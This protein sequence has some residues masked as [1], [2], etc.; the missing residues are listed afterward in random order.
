[1]LELCQP[2]CLIREM[3]PSDLLEESLVSRCKSLEELGPADVRQAGNPGNARLSK[4]SRDPKPFPNGVGS[5][6]GHACPFEDRR[7]TQVQTCVSVRDLAIE[8][9]RIIGRFDAGVLARLLL[10]VLSRL[11]R[12]VWWR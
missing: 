7:I 11:L 8:R 9:E 1:M 10:P 12:P 6:C 4:A 3:L 5:E 2:A